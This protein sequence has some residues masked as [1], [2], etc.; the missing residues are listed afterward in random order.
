MPLYWLTLRNPRKAWRRVAGGALHIRPLP[1]AFSTHGSPSL[2]AR[3]Q[4]HLNSTATT[5]V[6]FDPADDSAEAGLIAIQNDEHWYY[7]AVGR[8]GAHRVLRLRR[9]DGGQDPALG[10]IL[11]G[12]ALP[13]TGA[14]KLRIEAHGASY[15]FTWSTAGQPWRKLMSGADGTI[16]STKRAGGF[17]GAV[18]GLYAH[19]EKTREKR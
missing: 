3:R 17:V 4:Q 16:L 15:D 5:R 2:F 12:A 14:V 1:E 7:L 19:D 8:E 9:R 18:F 11:A 13:R 6:Q 10:T